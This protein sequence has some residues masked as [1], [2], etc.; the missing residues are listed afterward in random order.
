MVYEQTGV[1]GFLIGRGIW[2]KPWK[3]QE[4]AAHAQG[5]LYEVDK[6]FVLSCAVKHLTYMVEHYGSHAVYIFRKHLPFYMR[7]L[8]QA[9]QLRQQLVVCKSAQEV[10]DCLISLM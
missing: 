8:E 5:Q 10:T 1:D 3:L 2:A 4:M 7:G 6:K 9:S